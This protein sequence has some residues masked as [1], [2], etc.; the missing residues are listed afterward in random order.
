MLI[1]LALLLVPLY[2]A[3][4][5]SK[6]PP[7]LPAAEAARIDLSIADKKA[8]IEKIAKDAKAGKS[9]PFRLAFTEAEVNRLLDTDERLRGEM[10]RRNVERAWVRIKPGRIEATVELAGAPSSLSMVVKPSIDSANRLRVDLADVGVGQL[11]V[12]PIGKLRKLTD[13]AMA[14]V[15]QMTEFTDV[16]LESVTVGDGEVVVLGIAK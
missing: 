13:K 14:L 2:L 10:A 3:M 4:T 6:P 5:P 1:A 11:G 16:R 15:K 12:P 7:P 8:A 9:V